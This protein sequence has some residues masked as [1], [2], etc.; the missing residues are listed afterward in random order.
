MPFGRDAERGLETGRRGSFFTR[1]HGLPAA[2][3]ACIMSELEQIQ[4]TVART[5]RR[6]R[7]QNAWR[8]LWLGLFLGAVCWL[9]CLVL[10][11]LLPLPEVTL[12]AAGLIALMLAPAG[13]LSGWFRQVPLNQTARWIDSHE[14][15]QERLSTALEVA[16]DAKAGHWR[17]LLLADAAGHARRFNLRTSLPYRLPATTRWT[18]LLLV[19]GVGLGFVPEYRSQRHQEKQREIAIMQDTGRRLDELVRREMEQRPPALESTRLALD[20]VQ[21]LAAQLAKAKLT[22]TDALRE[23]ASVTE[24]L[25]EEAREL[26]RN[27]A[28][29]RL[30]QAARNP[31]GEGA[32]S[33][34][35]LQR[36][37][38]SL[39]QQL[40]QQTGRSGGD[41]PDE[42]RTGPAATGG[43][44]FAG[45]GFARCR[46]GASGLIASD[47]R[48]GAAGGGTGIVDSES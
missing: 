40:G 35:N 28:L 30:D 29:R 37:I 10:Y 18:L 6:R 16:G 34:S 4:E 38:E 46:R 27:P 1:H 19:L 24:R 13:F 14:H 36:Q 22:R 32:R 25:R 5:A 43:G 20:T 44:W 39:Q 47:G 23:L 31:D 15:F 48:P 42:E 33:A 11:K 45:S 12:P 3:Y 41:G 9:T 17:E 8:G 2:G 7:W 21:D 26:G